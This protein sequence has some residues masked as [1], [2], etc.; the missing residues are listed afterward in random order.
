MFSNNLKTYP[1]SPYWDDFQENVERDNKNYVKILFRPGRSIQSRELTQM[2]T[3]LQSQ[4]NKFGKSVYKEGTQVIGGALNIDN[5]VTWLKVAAANATIPG[6]PRYLEATNRITAEI[7]VDEQIILYSKVSTATPGTDIRL[8]ARVIGS[9][10]IDSSTFLYIKYLNSATINGATVTQF[11]SN[12]YL[13]MFIKVGAEYLKAVQLI[14][15]DGNATGNARLTGL[16][17]RISVNAGVYFAAGVFV[18]NADQ[19]IFKHYDQGAAP[20]Y[21]VQLNGH[22]VFNIIHSIADQGK[23]STLLDNSTGSN[24]YSAPGADRHQIELNLDFKSIQEWA[25]INTAGSHTYIQINTITNGKVYIPQRTEYSKL[26]D[27]LAT[28]TYEESGNYSLKP[29]KID[30]REY[31]KILDPARGYIIPTTGQEA[32]AAGKFVVGVEPSIAYVQGHRVE[33]LERKDIIVDKPRTAS[34]QITYNN[35]SFTA[36]LG[37]YI[38]GKIDAATTAIPNINVQHYTSSAALTQVTYAFKDSS[39]VP[40]QL[41]TCTINSI[42]STST[43]GVYRLF[44]GNI[45]MTGANEI[46]NAAYLTGSVYDNGASADSSGTFKFVTQTNTKFAL[47]ESNLNSLLFPLPYSG[48][49]T[50]VKFDG[51]SA[52]SYPTS[53]T[54]R[55]KFIV[56]ATNTTTAQIGLSDITTLFTSNTAADYIVFNRT[57]PRCAVI[58]VTGVEIQS[59]AQTVIITFNSGSVSTGDKLEIITHIQ[60]DQSSGKKHRIKTLKSGVYAIGITM[61]DGQTAYS[62]LTRP[63]NGLATGYDS[64]VPASANPVIT[65]ATLNAD[66]L[67]ITKVTFKSSL[68]TNAALLT[69]YA[70]YLI[71]APNLNDNA[72]ITAAIVAALN[73]ARTAVNSAVQ[74]LT[75]STTA[76][77]TAAA[78]AAALTTLQGHYRTS[79]LASAVVDDGFGVLTTSWTAL[80]AKKSMISAAKLSAMPSFAKMAAPYNTYTLINGV[81]TIADAALLAAAAIA[82]ADLTEGNEQDIANYVLDNGQR[83]TS[84]NNGS[85]K[86][87]NATTG[88]TSQLFNGVVIYYEYYEHDTSDGY[89]SVDSYRIS[90]SPNSE[91]ADTAIAPLENIPSYRGLKL[92][93]CLDFR[94]LSTVSSQLQIEPNSVVRATV[95]IWLPRIDILT[96]DS[97]S[98]FNIIY[99]TSSL[100]PKTP[101]IPSNS[102]LLYEFGIP[103]YTESIKNIRTSFIENRRYTMRDIGDLE[104]RISNL[105]YSTTLSL[106]ETATQEKIILNSTG[107]TDRFKN[108][109]FVDGFLGSNLANV[110]HPGFRCAIDHRLGILRPMAKMSESYMTVLLTSLSADAEIRNDILSLKSSADVVLI[111][112][113]YASITTNVNPHNVFTWTGILELSPSTDNWMDTVRNP[114]I[115]ITTDIYNATT[116]A[117]IGSIGTVWN[118]WTTGAWTSMRDAVTV[119]LGAQVSNTSAPGNGFLLERTDTTTRVWNATEARQGVKTALAFDTLSTVIV[120]NTS[121][122]VIPFIRS[123]K[124]YFSG[125]LLKPN[126]VLYPFFDGVRISEYTQSAAE[127]VRFSTTGQVTL[128]TNDVGLPTPAAQL[129]TNA[130][131][132]IIG[133][134]IIPN[135][136][137][138]MFKTGERIFKLADQAVNNSSLVTTSAEA[139]YIAAGTLSSTTNITSSVRQAKIVKTSLSESRGITRSEVTTN[140]QYWDPLAQTFMIGD[141]PTGCFI[142][143]VD[144][145]FASKDVNGVPVTIHIVECENGIPTQRMISDSQVI[146]YPDSVNLDTL[147]N[148]ANVAT[149]FAFGA[150]I[151]LKAGVEY[152]LIITSMSDKYN[153]WIAETGGFDQ[154]QGNAG[155]RISKN[156]Y[157]GVFLTSQNA[158]TWTPEQNKDLKFTIYRARYS[159]TAPATVTFD[160]RTFPGADDNVTLL[161]LG[162]EELILPGTNIKWTGNFS[163]MTG[164]NVT[165]THEVARPIKS[166][167]NYQLQLRKPLGLTGTSYPN[168]FFTAKATLST[169]SEYITPL[170]D[171]ERVSLLKIDNII[172]NSSVATKDLGSDAALARYITPEI[173]LRNPAD[174]LNIYMN[175]SLPRYTNVKVYAKYIKGII[176]SADTSWVAVALADG[177]TIPITDNQEE[178]NEVHFCKLDE[179]TATTLTF[180]SFMIKIEMTADNTLTALTPLIKAFRAIA[181]T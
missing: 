151:Y 140:T 78:A 154:T 76:D 2:Q 73:N 113:P 176:N 131:G 67:R 123:R 130:S 180:N 160:N 13:E 61:P 28:R 8:Q 56:T 103:S 150:P 46:A 54:G 107:G 157:M 41:G 22:V 29:F 141:I 168:R 37:N 53:Y 36:K 43:N 21:T 4:I 51:V 172:N 18:E 143:K 162:A 86:Y 10:V 62:K 87:V 117:E 134:F 104:S 72:T 152:A 179:D 105:E 166:N 79:G 50:L 34:D 23:D 71:T 7:L 17:S 60:I 106:L 124:V 12:D 63:A 65:S 31:S 159:T 155:N 96:V 82:A 84:Y 122:T 88:A 121:T 99:G 153:L 133:S 139:L 137:T 173:I 102:M 116:L 35:A 101:A 142:T 49:K 25:I 118:S 149:S 15:V 14:P 169:T 40:V 59:P 158:S 19:N 52:Y 90:G 120:S 97:N 69:N 145:Y 74:Y 148:L 167:E 129:R 126:T 138:L 114:D 108:G 132:I 16:A 80:Q 55:Y 30:L 144:L 70:I 39:N 174:Q 1:T 77:Q 92:S 20:D 165:P 115:S 75:I 9:A 57:A 110:K 136:A 178:F 66:V 81:G 24:N 125:R 146:V 175:I 111:K 44:I 42:E 177:T 98:K 38:L 89:F 91:P 93:D 163:S 58:T 48:V 156:P 27:L 147:N 45:S 135:T 6:F 68:A 95:T 112:Q 85:L 47:F 11:N 100:I 171:L 26:D 181:S 94:K 3:L 119:Q 83:D 164:A 33:L 32:A 5:N 128:F 109:F 127:F 64:E 161:N 170:I